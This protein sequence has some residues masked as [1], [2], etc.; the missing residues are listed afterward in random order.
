MSTRV[1]VKPMPIT[2]DN[3]LRVVSRS[4]IAH[5]DIA[6]FVRIYGEELSKYVDDFARRTG[7]YALAATLNIV[8]DHLMKIDDVIENYDPT[9]A[10]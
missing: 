7:D 1:Y 8:A 3:A 9:P 5:Y 6:D 4:L 10:E 2:D